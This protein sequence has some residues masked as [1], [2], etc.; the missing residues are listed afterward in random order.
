MLNGPSSRA[1]SLVFAAL[2]AL[3]LTGC[4]D[5]DEGTATTTAAPTSSTTTSTTTTIEST[6]TSTE[7][8]TTATASTTGPSTTPDVTISIDY[9]CGDGDTGSAE[10]STDDIEEVD[11]FVNAADL[12]EFKEG[13]IEISFT[14]PCPSGDRDVAV[15]AT[16]GAVPDIA[17]LDLCENP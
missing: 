15:A 8:A 16:D 1:T 14:A 9:T 2:L 17:T 10:F 4:G 12:C 6:T 3:G 7:S 13:L 11:D 5:D